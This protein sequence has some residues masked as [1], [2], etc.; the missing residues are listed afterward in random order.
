MKILVAGDWHAELPWALHVVDKAVEFGCKTI[1]QLGDFGFW[2]HKQWGRDFLSR[3]NKNLEERNI[4]LKWLDGNHENFDILYSKGCIFSHI[5]HQI[6]GKIVL[7]GTSLCLFMGGAH[8]IDVDG[9]KRA[10][11]WAIKYNKPRESWW[12]QEMITDEDIETARSELTKCNCSSVDILF[13]HDCP[14]MV[15]I[16]KVAIARNLTDYL[17]NY[18]ESNLN[19]ERLQKV[20]GFAKPT[21]IFH[22]HYHFS[23]TDTIQ[24][25]YGKVRVQGLA[26][27]NTRDNFIVIDV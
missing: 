1:I 17:K 16:Q 10:D 11:R 9:R 22:G 21:R 3:L 2:P 5:E 12:P 20:V 4:H 6:R 23:Y 7:I 25:D 15:D 14:M 19:R 27:E 24:T 18:P 26:C 8:S 13:S